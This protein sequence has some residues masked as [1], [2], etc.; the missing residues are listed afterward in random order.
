MDGP[1]TSYSP[2]PGTFFLVSPMATQVS[3]IYL[4]HVLS[5]PSLS[6]PILNT[7]ILEDLEEDS[8]AVH[9]DPA[10]KSQSATP[11]KRQ[12]VGKGKAVLSEADLRRSLRLKKAHKG[13]KISTC[14]ERNYLGCSASPPTISPTI[15]RDLGATFFNINL[16]DLSDAN[17]QARPTNKKP[18]KKAAGKAKSSEAAPKKDGDPMV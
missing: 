9:V 14:K 5:L 17:L 13:F 15:I 4:L 8:E 6:V 10:A 3:C 16:D 1:K 7:V 18:M 11:S 2:Q 12:R